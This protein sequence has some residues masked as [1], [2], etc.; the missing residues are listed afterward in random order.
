VTGGAGFIGSTVVESLLAAGHGVV[1]VDA[2]TPYYDPERKR[3]NLDGAR[4]S[5]GC[6]VVE[7]DLATDDLD[8]VLADADVVLHLAAQPGVRPSWSEFPLYDRQNVAAT[9]RLLEAM[10]RQPRP[11]KLVYTSSSSVYGESSDSVMAPGSRTVPHSPYGVTKLAAEHL[12]LAYTQNFGLDSVLL[13]LFT[14]YGV[15]QRP[16]MAFAKFIDAA[17]QGRAIPVYGNGEQT[18]D[19]TYVQ[20]AADA[21]IA[22][23]TTPVPPGSVYNVAGG[24][25]ATVLDVVKHLGNIL[26]REVAV[27]YETAAPGDVSW[28]AADTSATVRDLRWSPRV[29]LVD[30]LARQVDAARA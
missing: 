19:Y 21:I 27:A 14:V 20:D 6:T 5:A 1:A 8:A 17:R 7:A 23:A 24:A 29:P 3:R 11:A 26:G 15:R 12:V 16:D 4:A 25:T 10:M 18:R 13:R 9:A 30:G 22:A 28:T 2:F